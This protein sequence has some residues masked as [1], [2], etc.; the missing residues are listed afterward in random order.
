[1]TML[2]KFLDWLISRGMVF[3]RYN[4][5]LFEDIIITVYYKNGDVTDFYYDKKTE[6][7]MGYIEHKGV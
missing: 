2:K 3:T 5:D 6:Y 7:F 1:M 4:A